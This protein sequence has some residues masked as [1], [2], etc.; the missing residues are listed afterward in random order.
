VGGSPSNVSIKTNSSAATASGTLGGSAG[1]AVNHNNTNETLNETTTVAATT[2]FVND[3]NEKVQEVRPTSLDS[4]LAV[5]K[6]D[7][8]SIALFMAKPVQVSTFNWTSSA[9]KNSNLVSFRVS[10][11]LTGLSTP[12]IWKNKLSGYNLMRGTA[13]FK[14]ILNAQP[15]QAGRLLLH[16][17][18]NEREFSAFGDM[19]VKQHNFS[20]CQKTQHP[21]VELD[22]QDGNATIKIPYVAPALWYSRDVG[23]DWGTLYI[24]VLS[25]LR[26]ATSTSVNASVYL[27]FD[28]FELAA[29]IY[30]PE[31]LLDGITESWNLAKRER[32]RT[33]DSGVVT[34]FFDFVA[35]PLDILSSVPAIG[36]TAKTF[37]N[38]AKSL[39]DFTSYFGWSRP[40]DVKGTQ[41]VKQHNHYRGFNFNGTTTSDVLA[42][43]SMNQLVPMTNFAG[44]D[45]DEM[46]FNYLKGIPAYVGSFTWSTGDATNTNLYTNIINLPSIGEAATR[47]F[48]GA[49]GSVISYPPFVYLGRYFRYYRGGLVFTIKIV[50]TQFHSG[51][52]AVTFTPTS[53][54]GFVPTNAE[55]RSY[56][57]RELIDVR[58]SDTFSFT[59]PY[60]H[61]SPYLNTGFLPTDASADEVF[62][63][64]K[65]D[66]LNP[67][68]AASTVSSQIEA[69][70]YVNAAEDF[71]YSAL[72][73]VQSVP[74]VP[75][76]NTDMPRIS[77]PIGDAPEG[78]FTISPNALCTGEMFTSVKQLASMSRPICSST[79]SAIGTTGYSGASLYPYNPGLPRQKAAGGTYPQPT[80]FDFISDLAPGFAY[81]RGGIRISM[82]HAPSN[83]RSTYAWHSVVVGATPL[84]STIRDSAY[85][86]PVY[87]TDIS[88]LITNNRYLSMPATRNA[89]SNLLDVICPHYGQTPF[90]L[91]YTNAAYGNDNV[92][93]MYDSPDYVVNLMV[94]T[95][96]LA[97]VPNNKLYRSGADDYALGYFLGFPPVVTQVTVV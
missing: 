19:Y 52:L 43:D 90:R 97:E 30:G 7:D 85:T 5:K 34:T 84:W 76:M 44:S 22:I 21:C 15:F 37:G 70:I 57:Y 31:G 73:P 80:S 87:P 42:M 13:V 89:S 55:Q 41:I 69:L 17:L 56:V 14:I 1:G 58:E 54:A 27:H 39:G 12:V 78:K 93:T 48:N 61:P 88:A 77:G 40:Y 38:L 86:L 64:F 82:P 11:F 67:L 10:D 25:E 60:M 20:L 18:P 36:P 91:N 65:I 62:G 33:K 81:S 45:V 96:A 29:P 83:E 68:V 59:L 79:F 49:S 35:K 95:S 26:S 75:E 71:Q 46:A 28:D 50:K 4:E 63:F 72:A 47:T 66:I 92:P 6:G 2:L 74:F 24:D 23:Y 16:F 94:P 8:N 3:G 32:N 9:T 51:R 53:S